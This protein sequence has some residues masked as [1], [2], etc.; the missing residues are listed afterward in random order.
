MSAELARKYKLTPQGEEALKQWFE[1]RSNKTAEQWS[2]M[3][4][5]DGTRLEDVIRASQ[6]V[7]L[8]EGLDDFMPTILSGD[9]LAAFQ[10]DRIKDRAQRVEREADTK[11]Q[12]L[13]AIVGLS[14]AQKDQ[15]FGIMARSSRDYDSSITLN[16][17]LGP[18]GET[19]GGDPHEAMLSVLTPD[20]R[21]TYDAERQRR[22]TQAAKD[23][24]AVGLTL[25][26]NWE[27]LDENFR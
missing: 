7:R 21:A 18:I 26:P 24:A 16:G 2:E 27:F 25:P 10:A 6:N 23:M 15:V 5:R 22:R 9:N 12:R 11:V 14:E 17:A 4:A 20:Q 13:D 19:P 1:E 3:V 8:D